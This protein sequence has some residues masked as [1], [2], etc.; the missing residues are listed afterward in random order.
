MLAAGSVGA[1]ATG[2]G[3]GDTWPVRVSADGGETWDLLERIQGE[4]VYDLA[5]TRR[6]DRPTLFIAT[7]KG[8]RKMELGGQGGSRV[9]DRLTAAGS[10]DEPGADGFFAVAAAQHVL[11]VVLVAAAAREKKGVF[12]SLGGGEA[13]TFQMIAG[14][15]GKDIRTLLFQ[16]DGD[17]LFLWAGISAEGGAEGEGAM[18]IEARSDGIDPGGWK[19][20]PKGW[21]GGSCLALDALGHTIVAGS[22]HSGVLKLDTAG[23]NAAWTASSLDSGLPISVDRRALA[24]VPGVAIGPADDGT[25]L[26]AGGA[27]GL[28][29]STDG[30]NRYAEA[31]QTVFSDEAP[32][33]ANWLYCSGV[34]ALTV[35]R[36][37]EAEA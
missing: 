26:L 19:P 28:F 36:D 7:R 34:H 2:D 5:W 25:L 8:L 4:S 21:K 12:L 22:N 14:S 37:D 6:G 18:R 10:A 32:L 11:G 1:S 27:S 13:G 23:A 15:S 29:A 16:R 17:R 3:D 9:I 20:T 33:P 30:G 35:V 24:P 31:G